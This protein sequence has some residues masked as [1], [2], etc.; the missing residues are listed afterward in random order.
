MKL[1]SERNAGI[2]YKKEIVKS[3]LC[4]ILHECSTWNKSH[5]IVDIY[6]ICINK[7]AKYSKSVLLF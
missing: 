7:F 5:V 6:H 4:E 3:S 1:L 2:A